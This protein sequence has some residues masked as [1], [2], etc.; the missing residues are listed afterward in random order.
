MTKL[1]GIDYVGALVLQEACR[2]GL[3]GGESAGEANHFRHDTPSAIV[4]QRIRRREKVPSEDTRTPLAKGDSIASP[5]NG[6]SRSV[7]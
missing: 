3:A 7:W 5:S 1:I 2:G 6:Q 4:E